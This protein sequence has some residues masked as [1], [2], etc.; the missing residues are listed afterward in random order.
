MSLI[1][2]TPFFTVKWTP[3]INPGQLP[4][5]PRSEVPRFMAVAW[6]A[7]LGPVYYPFERERPE[8]AL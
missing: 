1:S 7:K 8:I 3:P 2:S 6:R 5:N 4:A